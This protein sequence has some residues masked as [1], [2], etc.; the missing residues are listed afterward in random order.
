M[1]TFEKSLSL[2]T[3][4]LLSILCGVVAGFLVK[5]C[6]SVFPILK[7]DLKEIIIIALTVTLVLV[8]YR[9][10]SFMIRYRELGIVNLHNTGEERSLE[11]LKEAEEKYY[12]LGTS[13]YY[14]IC[15]PAKQEDYFSNKKE[16]EFL[17]ITIDPKCISAIS[18]QSNWEK[19][20]TNDLV[21][22][23]KNTKQTI[24]NL[25][26][27]HVNIKWEGHN[28]FPTFRIVIIDNKKVLVS[29]YEKGLRGS[30]GK[31]IELSS[32]SILGRWFTIF[33]QKTRL[34]N[35]RHRIIKDILI[36]MNSACNLEAEKLISN[37]KSK[38]N[39]DQ[40]L[41]PE[42]IEN[43]VNEIVFNKDLSNKL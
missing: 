13:A 27:K 24:E 23:I 26:K 18:E 36:E 12:W 16:T 38:F 41:R 7:V 19:L 14:V 37:L 6:E 30:R 22:F 35:I 33:F 32:D 8:I 9:F 20:D 2:R 42:M 11:G 5:V 40:K 28:V 21:N 4:I 31:Q 34:E 10:R 17:F 15:D 1:I 29:F 3:N 25:K 39:N 43:I